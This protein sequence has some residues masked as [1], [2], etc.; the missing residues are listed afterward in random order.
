MWLYSSL[1]CAENVIK[2]LK[3]A[4]DR[5]WGLEFWCMGAQCAIKRIRKRVGQNCFPPCACV[6]YACCGPIAPHKAAG[7]HFGV[8]LKAHQANNSFHGQFGRLWHLRL[9]RCGRQARRHPAQNFRAKRPISKSPKSSKNTIAGARWPLGPSASI[10]RC[11]VACTNPLQ[12]DRA[13]L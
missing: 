6:F 1:F 3:R 11:T 10:S 7:A 5:R 13:W 4:Q 12:N 2:I 9:K 8:F